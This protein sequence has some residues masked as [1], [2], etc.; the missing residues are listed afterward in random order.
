M[1]IINNMENNSLPLPIIIMKEKKWFVASC[2][3]LNIATQGETEQEVK[4]NMDDLIDEYLQDPDT[5]LQQKVV[6]V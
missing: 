2:P 6:A 3:L 4:E 5:A 1:K